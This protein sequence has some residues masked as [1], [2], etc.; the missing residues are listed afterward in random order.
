MSLFSKEVGKRLKALRKKRGEDQHQ[1]AEFLQNESFK[2]TQNSVS[3]WET[4]KRLPRPETFDHILQKCN[5][6]VED[7]LSGESDKDQLIAEMKQLISKYER[8]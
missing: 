5:I 1:F 4:G 8:N 7:F 2:V 6:T 3:Y